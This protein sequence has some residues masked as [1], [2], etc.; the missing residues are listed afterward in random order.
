MM[1]ALKRTHPYY[2][3]ACAREDDNSQKGCNCLSCRDLIQLVGR[4]LEKQ[5]LRLVSQKPARCRKV[6]HRACGQFR[7]RSVQTEIALHVSPARMDVVRG[8]AGRV[9]LFVD[10]LDDKGWPL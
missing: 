2:R 3:M 10:V 6:R 7:Q 4:E 8:I 9:F 5:V 1:F